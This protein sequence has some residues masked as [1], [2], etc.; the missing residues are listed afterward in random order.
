MKDTILSI[1]AVCTF[2]GGIYFLATRPK[3]AEWVEDEP[4]EEEPQSCYEA[5][6]NA[7]VTPEEVFRTDYWKPEYEG[8]EI[9]C[10]EWGYQYVSVK[11]TC[12]VKDKRRKYGHFECVDEITIWLRPEFYDTEIICE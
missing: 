7:S 10:D 3:S 6:Q 8:M 12:F 1:I 9:E 4:Q 5:L 2:A 11:S